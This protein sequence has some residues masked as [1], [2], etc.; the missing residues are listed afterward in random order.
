MMTMRIGA[1]LALT[2]ALT[3]GACDRG[4]E[5]RLDDDTAA[6]VTV[7]TGTGGQASAAADQQD[8]ARADL[9]DTAS[10]LALAGITGIVSLAGAAVVRAWRRRL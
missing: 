6:I 8:Q 4:S 10:P 5:S 1:L 7:P 2:T 9:P 3:V